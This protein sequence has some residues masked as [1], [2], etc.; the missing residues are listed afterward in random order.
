MIKITDL[1]ERLQKVVETH[2]DGEVFLTQIDRS[3]KLLLVDYYTF[4]YNET[5]H[6]WVKCFSEDCQRKK[7]QGVL[8]I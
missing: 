3:E 8:L 1:I 6:Y 5:E 4:C 2:G 7:C